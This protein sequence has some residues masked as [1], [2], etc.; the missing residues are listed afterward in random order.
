MSFIPFEVKQYLNQFVS[1]DIDLAIQRGMQTFIHSIGSINL[2][3]YEKK[4]KGV[5]DTI[6]THIENQGILSGIKTRKHDLQYF[7]FIWG[8]TKDTIVI[9]DDKP[10][11]IDTFDAVFKSLYGH[12]LCVQVTLNKVPH[13]LIFDF[14]STIFAI[15]ITRGLP[16]TMHKYA[17]IDRK[18]QEL[19]PEECWKDINEA[20]FTIMGIPLTVR[21]FL[22]AH[23]LLEYI[24]LIK[25]YHVDLKKV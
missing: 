18:K 20:K 5:L 14:S 2:A 8:L 9:I 4:G 23:Y 11:I 15:D 24:K 10:G 7:E 21:E 16:K 25:I 17:V 1:L 6:F 12:M 19:S 3:N 13:K 22:L